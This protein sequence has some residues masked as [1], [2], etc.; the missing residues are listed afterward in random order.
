[1]YLHA[2]QAGLANVGGD[3]LASELDGG[4]EE[5]EVTGGLLVVLD[6]VLEDVAGEGDEV[7]LGWVR[8]GE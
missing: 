8:H 2:D 7:G 6:L 1:M 3:K 4:E 5:G